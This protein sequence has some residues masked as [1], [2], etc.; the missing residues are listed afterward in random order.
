MHVRIVLL[1]TFVSV[2]FMYNLETIAT[3][4]FIDNIIIFVTNLK[5]ISYIELL[6]S[7]NVVILVYYSNFSI[8]IN[9]YLYVHYSFILTY[10]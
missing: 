2:T 6:C 4:K 9:Q 8:I 1:I 7:M 3:Q 5:T 10:N